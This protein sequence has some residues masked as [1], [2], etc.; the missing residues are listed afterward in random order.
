MRGFFWKVELK[1]NRL[2]FREIIKS[3]PK[4]L[5]NFSAYKLIDF[6]FGNSEEKNI[7]NLLKKLKYFSPLKEITIF[8]VGCYMG[9][10]SKNINT[11]L[12]KKISNKPINYYL[13][14]PNKNVKKLLKKNIEFDYNYYQ[15]GLDNSNT[16]K[17]FYLNTNFPASGSSL[18]RIISSDELWKAT[19]AIILGKK[20]KPF[21]VY[22]VETQSV[23]KFCSINN[24]SKIDILKID[25][26]GNEINV[27]QGAIKTLNSCSIIYVEVL[28]QKKLFDKK[29]AQLKQILEENNFILLNVKNILSVSIFSHLKAVDTTFVHKNLLN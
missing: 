17:N 9:K 6:L 23:D 7:V 4:Q 5:L 21:K 27:I 2:K 24:V 10:F 22:K 29:F 12:T 26:E 8:D 19:R 3:K 14:D 18:Q 1:M 20:N 13:F 15:L 28:D 16:V 11:E 25:V